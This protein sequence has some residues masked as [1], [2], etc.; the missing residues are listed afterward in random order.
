MEFLRAA[1]RTDADF[2]PA[3]VQIS[4]RHRCRSV[5]CGWRVEDK[6]ELGEELLGSPIDV[7]K[8][9]VAVQLRLHDAVR[10]FGSV[11]SQQPWYFC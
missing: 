11:G 1:V 4:W 10:G 2:R 3:R 6:R 8:V 7:L 9:L 5:S